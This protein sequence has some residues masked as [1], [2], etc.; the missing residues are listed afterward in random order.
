MATDAQKPLV[1]IVDDD[2]TV[3]ALCESTVAPHFRTISA[4]NGVEALRQLYAHKPDLILLD[5][6]MPVLDG[7]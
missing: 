4:E 7:W 6:G 2:P 3:R 5:I 1:L